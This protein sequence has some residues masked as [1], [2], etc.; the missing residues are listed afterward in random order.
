MPALERDLVLDHDSDFTS[1]R[2]RFD[3]ALQMVKDSGQAIVICHFRPN[4]AKAL[5]VYLP[6]LYDEGIRLV[7]LSELIP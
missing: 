7:H 4:T 1:I 3:D 2:A 6:R 5:A